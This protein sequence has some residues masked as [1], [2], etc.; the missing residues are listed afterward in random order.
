MEGV[1]G[2][3][4]VCIHVWKACDIPV[5]FFIITTIIII[6]FIFII[7]INIILSCVFLKWQTR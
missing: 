2:K 1:L 7:I 5:I 6:I 3:T 4:C